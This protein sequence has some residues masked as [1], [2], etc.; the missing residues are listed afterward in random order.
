MKWMAANGT[1]AL[2]DD[3]DPI[4]DVC[5][6]PTRN[7]LQMGG[8]NIRDLLSGAGVIW[9]S[10]MGGFDLTVTNPNGTTGCVR[11]SAGLPGTTAD[12]IPHHACFQYYAST[13]NANHTRPASVKERLATMVRPIINTI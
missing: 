13:L 1:L 4:G 12:Y 11:S 5:S 9:G 8:T 10:F 7:Q 3:A 6:N 2:I